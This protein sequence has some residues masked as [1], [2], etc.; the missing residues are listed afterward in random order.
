MTDMVV[1]KKA[2]AVKLVVRKRAVVWKIVYINNTNLANLLLLTKFL[3]PK[4]H[5]LKR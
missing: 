4:T 1:E 5:Y 2:S 3:S